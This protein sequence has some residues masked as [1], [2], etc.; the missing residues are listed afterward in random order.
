MDLG[1]LLVSL[2]FKRCIN[3]QASSLMAHRY[4]PFKIYLH[5]ASHIKHCS[6]ND[7]ILVLVL[8]LFAMRDKKKGHE[9]HVVTV[10]CWFLTQVYFAVSHFTIVRVSNSLLTCRSFGR[11]MLNCTWTDSKSPGVLI[12]Y[13]CCCCCW[14]Y[15]GNFTCNL[16]LLSF[17]FR[18]K[19]RLT[20]AGFGKWLI[21]S[22]IELSLFLSI[23]L[24][25]SQG[26]E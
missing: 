16:L 7:T 25:W 13:R 18:W 22:G 3:Q 5:D 6:A 15:T 21:H 24:F 4:H 14:S 8:M 20:S 12:C 23:T 26:E 9:P 19:I 17:A 10:C 2:S 1:H 11:L